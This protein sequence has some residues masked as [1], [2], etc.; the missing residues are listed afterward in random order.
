MSINV[1]GQQLLSLWNTIQGHRKKAVAA[2]QD[3]S[4]PIDAFLGKVLD[5]MRDSLGS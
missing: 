4:A 1:L 2:N 3:N 5:T